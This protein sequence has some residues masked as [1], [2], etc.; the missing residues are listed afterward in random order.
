MDKGGEVGIA[1]LGT[2]EHG[3]W[4]YS[5]DGTQFN[6]VAAVSESA[7]LLLPDTALLRYTPDMANGETATLVYCA[8]DA[9]SGTAGT[10]VR[11]ECQGR[12]RGFQHKHGY[13][14]ANSDR[15]ERCPGADAP[16][17]RWAL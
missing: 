12:H 14:F 17:L 13:R 15:R 16:S 1:L 11:R 7:A 5:L 6:A 3:V 4:S 10:K 9:T 2:T 8:W